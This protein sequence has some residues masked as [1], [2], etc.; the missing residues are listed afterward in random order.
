MENINIS[1]FL[2]SGKVDHVFVQTGQYDLPLKVVHY[3]MNQ[4]VHFMDRIHPFTLQKFRGASWRDMAF[5]AY[6]T[7][8]P[9]QD[10]EV[11]VITE[12]HDYHVYTNSN[13]VHVDVIDTERYMASD[14]DKY[15]TL[16]NE[17]LSH[18][19]W[20]EWSVSAYR[21]SDRAYKKALLEYA[22]LETWSWSDDSGKI[23]FWTHTETTGEEFMFEI[24]GV[25]YVAEVHE[26]ADKFTVEGY[27]RMMLN[28]KAQGCDG[29]PDVRT[30]LDEAEEIK[31]SLESLAQMLSAVP[32]P[33]KEVKAT[34]ESEQTAGAIERTVCLNARDSLLATLDEFIAEYRS[35]SQSTV[36]HFG[37]KVDA[38]ETA[39]KLVEKTFSAMLSAQ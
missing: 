21:E 38:M 17:F 34:P 35:I 12:N 32:D 22:E 23:C 16:L 10:I 5:P 24:P 14:A 30:V 9:S 19:D 28:D 37:G 3:D 15:Q 8:C 4:N 1:I 11:A 26:Y 2:T 13:Q 36:D 27:V 29:I 33:A 7:Q 18:K 39:K 31:E 20:V 6:K 25:D